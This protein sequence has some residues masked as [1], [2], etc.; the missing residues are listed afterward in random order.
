[1]ILCKYSHD[2]VSRSP[3][4][5]FIALPLRLSLLRPDQP[6][7]NMTRCSRGGG[8]P[9]V[10]GERGERA[11]AA[12]KNNAAAIRHNTHRGARTHDHKVKGLALCRLS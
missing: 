3:T 5:N 2:S 6:L 9:K 11:S 10:G 7:L 4:A 12:S 1:M 8:N